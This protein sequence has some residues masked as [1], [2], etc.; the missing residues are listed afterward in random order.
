MK[1]TAIALTVLAAALACGQPA[2]AQS[3]DVNSRAKVSCSPA[4]HLMSLLGSVVGNNWCKQ[5]G[6][7]SYEKGKTAPAKSLADTKK[8]NSA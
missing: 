6:N 8:A 7:A 5:S 3:K 4:E 1:Q 2:L